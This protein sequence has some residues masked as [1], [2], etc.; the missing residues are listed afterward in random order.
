LQKAITDNQQ[1]WDK[2]APNFD[3]MAGE[4]GEKRWRNAKT[5][6]YSSMG[7]GD[8]LFMA[9]GT[10]QDIQAF[11][12]NK[13]I[14]A[15]DISPKMLEIASDRVAAYQGNIVAQQ[16]DI[17]QPDFEPASFDQ[18]FTSCTFCSVPTPIEGLK[19]VYNLLRPGGE[20]LMF[21]HTQS[22]YF[23]F[24]VMLNLMTL[25]TNKIGP[26]MNRN[27]VANVVAAGFEI[28]QVENVFID[29]VKIIRARKPKHAE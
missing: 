1:K 19:Q 17:L 16:M 2:L 24:N 10:G 27:T 15:I 14:T 5:Y 20:L 12:P 8:I 29:V 4:G 23:P 3:V 22:R 13:T 18:V 21:E 11:P 25:L 6:L 28:E 26:D 9:L 7:D